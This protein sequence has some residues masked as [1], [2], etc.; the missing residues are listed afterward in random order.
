M[1]Q[2]A[3]NNKQLSSQLIEFGTDTATL[4]I[5]DPSV[6]SKRQHDEVDWWSSNFSELPEVRDG[7]ITLVGL[8]SD[9]FFKVRLTDD[10]LTNLEKSYAR[11]VV[12]TGVRVENNRIFVGQGEALPGGGFMTTQAEG[13]QNGLFIGIENDD[14]DLAIY[15]I[16]KT[17]MQYEINESDIEKIADIVIVIKSRSQPFKTLTKEPRLFNEFES[18]LFKATPTDEK[19]LLGREG[20]V[21]VWKS[22]AT[23]SG[24]VLKDAYNE[25]YP[26]KISVHYKFLLK[27]MSQVKWQDQ[28]KVKSIEVDE[29]NKIIYFEILER[30]QN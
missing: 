2:F 19:I 18:F 9:G 3:K 24:L 17:E 13:S 15:S 27:D 5:F 8:G 28:L 20:F 14:Y 21:K 22:P 1:D 29:A 23:A 10:A 26:S 16:D 25:L 30:Q 7:M 11:E 6:L 4:A 12:H